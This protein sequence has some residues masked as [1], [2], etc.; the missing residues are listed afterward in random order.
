M[1]TLNK[2]NILGYKYPEI[3]SNWD[4]DENKRL[5]EMDSKHPLTPF[6]VAYSSHR[7][8]AMKCDKHG[9]YMQTPSHIVYMHTGCPKCAQ[10]KNGS[11]G[12]NQPDK[13]QDW[14]YDENRK[15]HSINNKHPLTPFDVSE[16]SACVVFMKCHKCGTSVLWKNRPYFR[17]YMQMQTMLS[18]KTKKA[19]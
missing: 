18:N 16:H 9:A 4:Y 2:N 1:K 6:D 3:A 19:Y 7:K 8:V 17:W 10:L 13:A 5:H 12:D 14:D 15:A 11:F